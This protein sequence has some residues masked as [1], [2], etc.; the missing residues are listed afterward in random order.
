M[1]EVKCVEGACA[2][3]SRMEGCMK[4]EGGRGVLATGCELR[5]EWTLG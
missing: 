2:V 5:E 3:D 1:E 4:E